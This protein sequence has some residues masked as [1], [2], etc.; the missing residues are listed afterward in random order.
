MKLESLEDVFT[1]LVVREDT[2][3]VA[4]RIVEAVGATY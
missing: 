4:T 2:A 3:G 1:Q